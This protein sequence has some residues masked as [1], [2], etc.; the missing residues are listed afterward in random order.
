M[1]LNAILVPMPQRLKRKLNVPSVLGHR[2]F[3]V[4]VLVVCVVCTRTVI[5]AAIVANRTTS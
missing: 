3:G 1:A 5:V 2:E 4:Q